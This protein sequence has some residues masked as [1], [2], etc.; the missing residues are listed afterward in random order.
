LGKHIVPSSERETDNNIRYLFA[1]TFGIYFL[2]ALIFNEVHLRLKSKKE[3]VP[4]LC[5]YI[6]Y[7]LYKVCD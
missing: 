5:V 3:R 1:G 2:N 7:P 6:Y 4:A